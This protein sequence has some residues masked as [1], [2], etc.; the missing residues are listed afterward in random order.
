MA[1]TAKP[2]KHQMYG[3]L[4]AV[5]ALTHMPQHHVTLDYDREADVL[6]V[7]FQKPQR[8][9][10]S[11]ILEDGIIIRKRGTRVV[12]FTILDAAAR[13]KEERISSKRPRAHR[14]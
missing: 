6:Y 5:P 9:T 13:E 4:T 14:G 8:A 2:S 7:S 1:I 10:D 11:E 12:G 3:F